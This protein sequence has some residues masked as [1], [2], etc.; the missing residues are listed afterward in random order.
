S[1]RSPTGYSG[2]DHRSGTGGYRPSAT[3]Q[4]QTPHR[5]A[6]APGEEGVDGGGRHRKLSPA[7]GDPSHGEGP[8]NLQAHPR[9][10][11]FGLEDGGRTASPQHRRTEGEVR[12]GGVPQRSRGSLEDQDAP[13]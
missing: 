6:G 1:R 13:R 7:E 2:S 11:S 8:A 9:D 12:G 5:C 4:A 10:P 3:S